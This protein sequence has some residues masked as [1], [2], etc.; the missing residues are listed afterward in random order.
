MDNTYSMGGKRKFIT[1]I[2][3]AVLLVAAVGAVFVVFNKKDNK[4]GGNTGTN[5]Q[6][7]MVMMASPNVRINEPTGVR[8]I[9]EISPELYN[10]VMADETKQFGMVL[11]PISYFMKVDLGEVSGDCDW[12]HA[13]EDEELTVLYID[14]IIPY[15]I[16]EPDGTLLGYRMNGAISNV[17]YGNTNLQFLGIGYVITTDGENVSYKYASFPDGLSYKQCSRSFAYVAAERLNECAVLTTYLSQADIDTLYNV[18][19]NSVDLANGL[20]EPTA[21]SS[22]Y[23]VTLSDVSKTI[24]VDEEFA[25][26]VDIAEAVPTSIWWQSS[27]TTVATVKDGVVTALKEGTTTI[28]AFV[29]GKEYKCVVTVGEVQENTEAVV[30]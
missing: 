21:D 16:T 24:G 13:F 6:Q 9:A 26:K 27:D 12:M 1:W 17:K 28:T 8:F 4:D 20:T 30:A 11:A 18:I 7:G 22:F 3:V 14:G 25:I 19:N 29:A 15:A 10:E 2:L 5:I 23:A